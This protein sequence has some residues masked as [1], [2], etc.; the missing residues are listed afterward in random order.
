MLSLNYNFFMKKKNNKN[1][2]KS[3]SQEK[4]KESKKAPIGLKPQ[5][6]IQR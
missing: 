4:N 2:E 1:S 5:K 3:D 6:V